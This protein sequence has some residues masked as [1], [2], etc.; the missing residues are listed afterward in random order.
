MISS[1]LIMCTRPIVPVIFIECLNEVIVD[2]I[3]FPAVCKR[4]ERLEYMEDD[5]FSSITCKCSKRFG[6]TIDGRVS[7]IFREAVKLCIGELIDIDVA[8]SIS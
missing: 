5:I 2:V 7:A 4:S 1:K 3:C 6:D 8:D